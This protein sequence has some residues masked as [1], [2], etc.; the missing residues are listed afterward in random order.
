[1]TSDYNDKIVDTENDQSEV[2]TYHNHTYV[3]ILTFGLENAPYP[4]STN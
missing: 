3:E 4:S 2:E 1:M